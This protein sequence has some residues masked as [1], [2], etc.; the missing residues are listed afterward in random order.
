M[1]SWFFHD[2]AYIKISFIF[3]KSEYYLI[4][5]IYILFIHLFIDV[6]LGCFHLLTIVNNTDMHIDVLILVQVPAFNSF[7]YTTK[8]ELLDHVSISSPRPSVD[9]NVWI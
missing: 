9:I 5:W 1:T 2:A 8:M 4:V 3:F 6:H 7:V